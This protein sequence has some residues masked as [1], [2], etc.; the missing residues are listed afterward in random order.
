[1]LPAAPRRLRGSIERPLSGRADFSGRCRDCNQLPRSKVAKAFTP[2]DLYLHRKVRSVHGISTLDQ[3]VC[4]VVSID[5]T[6]QAYV[7]NL[8]EFPCDGPGGR[9][10]TY[11]DSD[12]SP[13]YSPSGGQVAFISKRSGKQQLFCI[14]RTGGEARQVG[15]FE[16]GVG[17][18]RWM[19]S[20]RELIVRA[21]VE[22][23]LPRSGPWAR[24]P[25]GDA[26]KADVEVNWRLPYKADGVGPTLRRQHHLFRVDATS[27]QK[28]QLTSGPFDVLSFDVSNDGRYIAY[29]RTREGR[30]AHRMDLWVADLAT[31]QH[32]RLSADV[33]TVLQPAWSPDGRQ[34]AFTGAASEG[35]AQL[36][37]WLVDTTRGEPVEVLEGQ[38][39]VG[40]PESV[41]WVDDGRSIAFMR[42][43]RGR[44]QIA[45]VDTMRQEVSVLRAGDRQL[46]VLRSL[47]RRFVYTVLHP[48]IP[49][50]LWSCDAVGG[51]EVRLSQLNAWWEERPRIEAMSREF[52][53]PDG[54]GGIEKIEGW[55]IRRQDATG[56]GPLLDDVPR[57]PAS[58]AAFDFDT[59][60]YWHVLCSQ[61]W[62]VLALNAV[63]SASYGREFCQR[64]AGHWGRLDLPQHMAALDALRADGSCDDRIAIAG[65]SYGGTLSCWA[66]GHTQRFKAAVVI[67]PI[68]NIE[69]HYGT[70]DSG[71]HVD[72]FY[73]GSQPGFDRQLARELSPVQHVERSLTP[74]LFLQGKDDERCPKCQ[75]EELFVSLHRSGDTP[76]Q[77][78]LYPGE[79][80]R[81]LGHGKPACRD[82]AQQRIVAWLEY[83]VRG[84]A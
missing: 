18:H 73:L 38:I 6:T 22:E 11:G 32:R 25:D 72:P 45:K 76:T 42:T 3:V 53:V 49:G 44:H 64:L 83:H 30:Q 35:D 55:L 74:T 62:S 7:S 41:Q 37:L 19:P 1:M 57:G 70:S 20:G 5:R 80:H 28:T 82:D 54:K 84:G 63:G 48:S 61:G 13:R 52:E 2:D 59:N 65:T 51:S 71:Y 40:D 46:G 39:D 77:L 33:A 79:S 29:V 4:E 23:G 78:V 47:G 68:G 81:L 75:S 9:R 21:T 15:D 34:I 12:S 8:W 14:S 50:D 60:L 66:T 17:P 67:A 27:G 43:F 24:L 58:H 10:V 36:R 69:T 56:P 31:A 26:K 16:S